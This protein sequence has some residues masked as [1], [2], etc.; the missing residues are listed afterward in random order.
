MKDMVELTDLVGSRHLGG[1]P[2]AERQS[3]GVVGDD[4]EPAGGASTEDHEEQDE[5]THGQDETDPQRPRLEHCHP[6][7]LRNSL[8][9]ESFLFVHERFERRAGG[10]SDG[11]YVQP[12]QC[13]D[14]FSLLAALHLSDE[15]IHSLQRQLDIVL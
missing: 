12:S 11:F 8:A 5:A 15:L 14:G 1:Q 6:I 10:V 2:F 7:E 9:V 4:L 3:S 13:I